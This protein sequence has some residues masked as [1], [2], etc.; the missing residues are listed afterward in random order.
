MMRR[1]SSS[2]AAVTA[3][4]IKPMRTSSP[5]VRAMASR[6]MMGTGMTI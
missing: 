3:S 4:R 6:Q 1:A 5:K 2:T